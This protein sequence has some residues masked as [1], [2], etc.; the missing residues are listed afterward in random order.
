MSF[1]LAKT[2]SG[3][4]NGFLLDEHLVVFFRFRLGIRDGR[5]QACSHHEHNSF[6]HLLISLRVK[7][8]I[9]EQISQRK[10]CR[11]APP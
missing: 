6:L 5:Q 7:A 8:V 1:A 11:R 10:A 3:S 9:T 4:V 2:L